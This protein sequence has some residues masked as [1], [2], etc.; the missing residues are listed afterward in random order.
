MVPT[1][2]LK[3][4]TEVD[5]SPYLSLGSC[6]VELDWSNSPL[7]IMYVPVQSQERR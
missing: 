1:P 2:M 4:T 6:N 5:T 3:Y 7:Q